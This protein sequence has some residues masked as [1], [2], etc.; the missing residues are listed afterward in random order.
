MI[1]LN[2]LRDLDLEKS[3]IWKGPR[4]S[5]IRL[6]ILGNAGLGKVIEML[7]RG[8]KLG[9]CSVERWDAS[10]LLKH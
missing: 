3:L 6:S 8:K 5:T 2:V 10:G 4:E 1:Y 9:I 7:E